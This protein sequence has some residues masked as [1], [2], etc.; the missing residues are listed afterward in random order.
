MV[1]VASWRCKD[2]I[3]VVVEAVELAHSNFFFIIFLL[4][5]DLCI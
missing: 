5:A 4:A 2:V 1:H 3:K